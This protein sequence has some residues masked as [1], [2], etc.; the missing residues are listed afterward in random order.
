MGYLR[1]PLLNFFIVSRAPFIF[2]M[3]FLG[4][5]YQP[6]HKLFELSKCW[7]LILIICI[8]YTNTVAFYRCKETL[9][10]ITARLKHFLIFD[11]FASLHVHLLAFWAQS[12]KS[13]FLIYCSLYFTKCK[14]CYTFISSPYL[15]LL[16]ASPRS[17]LSFC[18]LEIKLLSS[19][20][21]NFNHQL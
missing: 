18:Y 11:K 4:M 3:Y 6:M 12:Q 14:I 10:Q 5:L 20:S 16:W 15:P 1:I 17:P 8:A 13:I 21:L 9:S 7:L 2:K 19:S